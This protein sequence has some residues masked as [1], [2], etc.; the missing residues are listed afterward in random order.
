MRGQWRATLRGVVVAACAGIVCGSGVAQPAAEATAPSLEERLAW[1]EHEFEKARAEHHAPGASLAVIRDGEVVLLRGFGV[2][3]VEAERPVTPDT[4][5]AVGSTTKAFTAT[6]VGILADE[7]KMSFDDPVKRHLPMFRLTDAAADEQVQ[8]RDLLCHRVGFAVAN[9]L[10]YGVPDIT[11]EEVLTTLVRAELL[12]PFRST[13]NY[14]NESFLAAGVAAG[15]AAGSDWDTL[16]KDRIF[17]PLGM[18][19]SNTTIA[20]AQADSEMAKGYMWD[21]EKGELTHQPMR[22]VDAV[23]PAGSINSSARDMSRWVLLQLGRGEIDGRRVISQEQHAATWEKQIDVAMGTISG[24]YGL[25]WFLGEWEG[26]PMIEHAGG[27]DGFTAEVAMLPEKNVGMVMLTNQFGSSLQVLSR[28]IVFRGLL[29]DISESAAPA[30]DFERFVGNYTA[31]FGPFDNTAMKVLEQNGRLAIDVPGQMVFELNPPDE[32]G[33]RFFVITDTISLRFNEHKGGAKDGEV[34]SLSMFQGGMEFELPREGSELPVEI[35]LGEAQRYLGRYRWE[36]AG[37][38]IPA[39]IHN[40]R[41]AL[42]VPGQMVFEL[43]P[44]D[45]EGW[46]LFRATPDIRVRFNRDGSGAVVSMTQLQGGVETELP[47]VDGAA[48]GGPALPTVG[49]IVAMVREAG[50]IGD[51]STMRP[52][53]VEGSMRMVHSGIE[54]RESG[55]YHPDGRMRVVMDSGRFGRSET[56]VG[57]SG[58]V[59][60]SSA[61]PEFELTGEA[62]VRERF[63]NPLVFATDWTTAFKEARVVGEGTFDDRPVWEV[64]LDA[65]EG[66]E[67]TI[68]VDKETHL[69]IAVDATLNGGLGTSVPVTIRLSDYRDA[70]SVKIP[71][72][73][74]I[75]IPMMGEIV[76]QTE[77]IEELSEVEA[78]TF[79]PSR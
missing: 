29:G 49:E 7:G 19:S 1:I 20:A 18:T 62:L 4:R 6:L 13:W 57:E 34:Y 64:H 47:R 16:I 72:R 74:A 55:V 30:E 53:R 48:A 15:N 25:G 63:V 79:D 52:V 31:D 8:I 5:F 77:T 38:E 37:V 68:R 56:V 40:N 24:S 39:I 66:A 42:D 10:W 76:F 61:E 54:G 51:A 46:M 73:A 35:D 9:G 11:R 2:A 22:R 12:Y 41:L 14:S 23:G 65:G 78:G 45:D 60:R 17:T 67:A 58:G 36:A 70:G 69:P 33:K 43:F 50:A 26:V 44:P 28:Q 27:I 59:T 71:G 32:D 75:T 3:D 21:A